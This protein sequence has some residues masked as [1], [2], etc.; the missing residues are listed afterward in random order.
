M[1]IALNPEN[2]R[3]VVKNPITS[4]QSFMRHALKEAGK[5]AAKGDVPIGAVIVKDGII[6]GRGH[7]EKE[8]KKDPTLHAEITAIRKASSSQGSWRLS[9][10]DIYVTLE[11]CPMC[12]GA[13]IQ[14]RIKR[15][16]IG[17]YDPKGGAAGSVIDIMSVSR[18]N[19]QV[20]VHYGILED[21]CSNILK[22]FFKNLRKSKTN[23]S[24][25]F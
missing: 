21:E 12:A 7:N 17:A 15:L 22:D 18:F 24:G 4:P 20:E 13:I 23:G 11:P 14:S 16:F 25:H 10:C 8:L 6:I 5:A 1:T 9:D 2:E 3:P 19:H